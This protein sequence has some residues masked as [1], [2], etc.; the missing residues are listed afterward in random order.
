MHFFKMFYKVLN[1][2]QKIY[3]AFLVVCMV[4]GGVIEAIGVGAIYPLINIIGNPNFLDDHHRIASILAPFH[5]TTHR[6]VIIFGAACLILLYIFKNVYIYVENYLQV[7]FSIKNE[8]IYG[9]RL[10]SIYLSKPYLFFTKTNSSI[11]N[12]NVS[13]IGGSVFEQM[14]I[15]VL[16]LVT[17]CVTIAIIWLMIAYVDLLMAVLTAFVLAPM[18]LIIINASR[19]KVTQLGQIRSK[20]AA[21]Y[22]KW[23]YQALGSIK[24]TKVMQKESYFLEEFSKAYGAYTKCVRNYSL[25]D[26]LPRSIIEMATMCGLFLLVIVKIASGAE[27]AGLVSSLGVLALAAV[28]MMPSVNRIINFINT[29]KY[30]QPFFDEI[31]DDILLVR[32]SGDVKVREHS[33]VCMEFNNE[34]SVQNLTFKYPETEKIILDNVSFKIPKGSF[35]GITG[36]SG[37]GKTTFVDILLGLLPP[38]NGR[39]LVDGKDI[40]EDIP[41]WLNNVAYVPQAVYLID[42]SIKDNIALGIPPAEVSDERI[43]EVL[44]MA[45]L[46]D[47]VSELP[48]GVDTKVGERGALL[49]GGQKQRIGIARALY[50]S[51][52][53]LVLDEATSALDNETEKNITRT[54][55]K[56][57]GSITIISIAHRLSTLEDADFKIHFDGGRAS[58]S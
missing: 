52:S 12:R 1:K 26:K 4:L 3:A 43:G 31:Y 56:L 36:A 42:G 7:N 48:A 11:L 57:K 58:L 32:N 55:L 23:L 28:R 21:E 18:M 38:E 17:E 29:I 20:S 15:A 16:S 54:I 25:I 34:I 37:A 10:F 24:E 33:D 46:Y 22:G 44:R 2:V 39:I 9:E 47:F 27:P 40:Y 35:V 19:K 13:M 49:S 53:V 8:R 5:I 6:A 30:N 50:S 45:E 51:P 14:L 41:A